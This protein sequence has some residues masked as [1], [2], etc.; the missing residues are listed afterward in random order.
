[1]VK[2]AHLV[3][4]GLGVLA[5]GMVAPTVLAVFTSFK[6]AS[7][8]STPLLLPRS[9][10][11]ENYVRVWTEAGFA[12]YFANSLLISTVD[13]VIMIL[14]ASL[15]AY[16][17]V[18]ISFRGKALISAAFLVGL[19]VPAAAIVLPLYSSM[20]SLGLI[21]SPVSVILADIALAL[22]IFVF[23]F[24]SY[25]RKVPRAL[26][27]AARMDGASE[28]QIYRTIV[29]PVARPVVVT[30]GLLEFLWSWNDLLLRLLLLP[31]EA[32]RTLAVGL[33]FFQ[34]AQTRDIT[35]L[36]AGT[37]IMAL[38]VVLLFIVFQRHFVRGMT[39]GA[40]K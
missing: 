6:M 11:I 37:V 35:S 2:S 19:M 17:L 10:T 30:T 22:P 3:P 34:G 40:V 15:A 36:S 9:L 16:A 25:F 5:A 20:R 32:S 38:P 4:T 31:Q 18:F 1:M 21:G 33:L 13:A 23:L 12:G 8:G 26:H 29:L 27:E 24:A 28:W 39:A 14:L 7:E